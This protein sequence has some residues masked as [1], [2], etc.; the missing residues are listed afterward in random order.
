MWR[1]RNGSK[2]IYY[3]HSKAVREKTA[4]DGAGV[5]KIQDVG[6]TR[7]NRTKREM[8]RKGEKVAMRRAQTIDGVTL[9][10]HV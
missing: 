9:Q 1:K 7:P 6:E 2:P 4:S 5:R 3:C 10:K 8:K